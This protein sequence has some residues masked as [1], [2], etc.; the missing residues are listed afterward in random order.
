MDQMK[1]R[2]LFLSHVFVACTNK[3]SEEGEGKVAQSPIGNKKI[4]QLVEIYTDPCD[5]RALMR[6]SSVQLSLLSKV[7]Y[8]A[9]LHSLHEGFVYYNHR[10]S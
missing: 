3:K 9:P 1:F 10:M 4:P 5:H 8:K 6:K 2:I 7:R